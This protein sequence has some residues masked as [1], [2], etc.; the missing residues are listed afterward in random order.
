[1]TDVIRPAPSADLEVE[2]PSRWLRPELL[3]YAISEQGR[4]ACERLTEEE[5]DGADRTLV[6]RAHRG[7]G[8]AGFIASDALEPGLRLSVLEILRAEGPVPAPPAGDRREE[9]LMLARHAGAAVD[10]CGQQPR[11][12]AQMQYARLECRNAVAALTALVGPRRSG[13]LE[14]EAEERGS[15]R[16]DWQQANLV[17]HSAQRMPDSSG[18][19]SD[20]APGSVAGR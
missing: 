12:A 5:P 15:F 2:R 1:M 16:E 9:A 13:A 11:L 3:A 17:P 8:R 4:L 14:R 18:R 20:P 6:R 10:R 19:L 7:L